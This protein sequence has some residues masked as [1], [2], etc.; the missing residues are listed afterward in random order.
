MGAFWAKSKAEGSRIEMKNQPKQ[1]G[2]ILEHLKRL[3][4]VRMSTKYA[5]LILV[6]FRHLSH[7]GIEKTVKTRRVDS[8]GNTIALQISKGFKY[9]A[10]CVLVAFRKLK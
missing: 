6:D 9:S 10:L 5:R 7:H 1:D 2:L 4:H 3:I 8:R